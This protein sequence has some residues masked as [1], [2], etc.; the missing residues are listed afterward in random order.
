M[1]NRPYEDDLATFAGQISG[2]LYAAADRFAKEFN[3][4]GDKIYA[5]IVERLV[6][7]LPQSVQ[8]AS[9]KRATAYR[10]RLTLFHDNELVADSDP[11]LAMNAPGT[12]VIYGLQAV[13]VW[14]R[15]IAYSFHY[16]DG[17][18]PIT[19][20]DDEDI[21]K[22]IKSLRPSL[23]RNNGVHNW[24]MKYDIDDQSEWMANILVV[25]E[26]AENTTP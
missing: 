18:G 5:E 14:A 20:L 17:P 22:S 2:S 4:P 12:E 10:V 1:T 23:S 24:R 7:N 3:V 13:G 15:E 8:N 26:A 19:G 6:A 25:T 16:G 9:D 11:E 21:A